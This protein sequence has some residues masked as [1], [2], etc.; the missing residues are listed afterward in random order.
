MSAC[1]GPAAEDDGPR[2]SIPPELVTQTIG[3]M[4]PHP[5]IDAA[6]QRLTAECLDR[7]GF[8]PPAEQPAFVQA[9]VGITGLRPFRRDEAIRFGFALRIPRRMYGT[10]AVEPADVDDPGYATALDGSGLRLVHGP[11]GSYVSADG[12]RA[13]ARRT[14]YGSLQSYLDLT[15]FPN[16]VRAHQGR[17]FT[18]QVARAAAGR[19]LDC[20]GDAGYHVGSF[21]QVFE[22]AARR[23][24][25]PVVGPEAKREQAMAFAEARCQRSSSVWSVVDRLALEGLNGWLMSKIRHVDRL[26]Q[27]EAAAE[28]RAREI[29][30]PRWKPGQ[31]AVSSFSVG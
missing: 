8:E 14:L 2:G 7:L 23:F 30:G 13:E 28:E 9:P 6:E 22:L 10:T 16:E 24:P 3:L 5:V 21:G 4:N 19:Y 11:L 18:T 15:W 26:V 27:L 17:W 20:M 12:C 1:D 29:V 31:P 25:D